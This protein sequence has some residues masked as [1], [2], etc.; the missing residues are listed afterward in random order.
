MKNEIILLILMIFIISC[1]G[2]D[3]S[4][5]RDINILNFNRNAKFNDYVKESVNYP[6]KDLKHLKIL[7]HKFDAKSLIT[8]NDGDYI[9]PRF[10]PDSRYLAYSKVLVENKM[11][12]TEIIVYDFEK[13]KS[14]ILLDSKSAKTY[15]IYKTFIYSIKWLDNKL[16]HV[17]IG[18]GDVNSTEITFDIDTGKQIEEKRVTLDEV[19]KRYKLKIQKTHNKTI[20]IFP[21]ID[22]QVL[23]SA[24]NDRHLYVPEKGLLIQKRMAGTDSHVWYFDFESKKTEI[25]VKLPDIRPAYRYRFGG[26]I[27]FDSSIIC[28]VSDKPKGFL[29]LHSKGKVRG[30]SELPVNIN[31]TNLMIK[32]QSKNIVAFMIKTSESDENSS[33]LFY[34]F[35]NKQ[36]IRVFTLINLY[37]V[38]INSKGNRIAISYWNN[39][40][41][42]ILVQ[43]IDFN[44]FNVNR[45]IQ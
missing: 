16:L 30:I 25:I 41:R 4:Y 27:I 32:Y 17:K 37:D 44:N 10:S 26:G 36:I 13:N 6:F 21:D 3:E 38:D 9:N 34:L 14:K 7:E 12:N 5:E 2:N 42:H 1:S 19:D 15:A 24:L 40:K 28:T 23:D 45:I 20:E 22:A 8:F 31:F 35:N 11:E 33:N 29:I 18:D 43:N 39:G